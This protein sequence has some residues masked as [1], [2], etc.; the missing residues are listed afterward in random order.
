MKFFILKLLGSIFLTTFL[1]ISFAEAKTTSGKIADSKKNLSTTNKDKK[2]ATRQL[3][4]IAKDMKQAEKSIVNLEKKIEDL[5]STQVKSEEKFKKLQQDLVTFKEE[6]IQI[7][8]TLTQKQQEFVTLLADQFSIGFAM[9]QAYEPTE[10]SIIKHEVYNAYKK[11]NDKMLSSLNKEMKTLKKSKEDKSYLRNK[12]KNEIARI[13][14]KKALYKEQKKTKKRLVKKLA[15]DEDI[16][17]HKLRKVVDKENALRSTLAKLNILQ[18]K[19]V[20]AARRRAEA[21]K[22]AIRLEKDRQKRIRKEKALARAKARKAKEALR[23]AKTKEQKRKAKRASVAAE[24][25]RKKVYKQSAKVRR[26]N[27]SYKHSPTYAYRGRKTSSPL[28]GS[29]VIKKFGT[30]TDPIYKMKI[31]NEGVTLKSSSSNA[32]V[33]NVLDGKVVF[34]GKTSMLGKVVVISHSYKMHTIYAG[35]SRIAPAIHKGAKIKG[36]A[37]IG[38]VNHKLIFQATKN[39]K[40]INPLRLIKI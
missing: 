30:Y 9:E 20:A 39:Q 32:K 2:R 13:V 18:G 22:E 27:S 19:E 24:K 33:Y 14:K 1:L 16:Y 11:E 40:H 25:A 17:S 31:F 21:K 15:A 28:P 26:V 37:I 12:T 29:R 38:K 34:A 35:L 7:S 5:E 23:R 4:K 6:Y 36:K 8:K 3:S 10:E